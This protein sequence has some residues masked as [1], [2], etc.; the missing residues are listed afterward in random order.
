MCWCVKCSRLRKS[1]LRCNTCH[2][3]TCRSG[4]WCTACSPPQ[5]SQQW[6]SPGLQC[7]SYHWLWGQS[8]KNVIKWKLWANQKLTRMK[9]IQN[10]PSRKPCKPLS[11]KTRAGLTWRM[12]FSVW[13]LDVKE[14][15]WEWPLLHWCHLHP[16]ESSDTPPAECPG[17]VT[18]SKLLHNDL[19]PHVWMVH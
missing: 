11:L 19:L 6:A 4:Q 13:C 14:P 16:L 15:I 9:Q 3:E 7:L 17:S 2:K 8:I 5:S 1:W 12:H 18:G 10:C